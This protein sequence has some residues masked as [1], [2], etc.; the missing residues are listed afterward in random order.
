MNLKAVY[1]L[2]I[3]AGAVT[4]LLGFCLGWKLWMDYFYR[5]HPMAH[6]KNYRETDG[7]LLAF[8]VGLVWPASLSAHAIYVRFNNWRLQRQSNGN[9][10]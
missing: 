6:S 1:I 7:Y 10:A 9:H 5:V 2:L 8:F 3:E 4:Y